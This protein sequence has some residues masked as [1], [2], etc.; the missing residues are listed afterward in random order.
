M[1][2]DEVRARVPGG[3]NT[4]TYNLRKSSFGGIFGGFKQYWGLAGIESKG[5]LGRCPVYKK[6]II[7]YAFCVLYLCFECSIYA[8]L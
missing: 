8:L 1:P 6:C 7:S 5:E 2:L 4:Y 3:K